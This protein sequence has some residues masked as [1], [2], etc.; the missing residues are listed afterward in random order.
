MKNLVSVWTFRKWKS[1]INKKGA[2][3]FLLLVNC[4]LIIVY[5]WTNRIGNLNEREI[6]SGRDKV[7][8]PNS[9]VWT[10]ISEDV[11]TYSAF[12]D[13]RRTGSGVT[14][15]V[16]IRIIGLW[17]LPPK[18][19]TL[20]ENPLFWYRIKEEAAMSPTHYHC[21]VFYVNDVGGLDSFRGETLTRKV[22][23]EGLKV[24]G[25]TFFNCYLKRNV[26]SSLL[27][28]RNPIYVAIYPTM[29]P[30]LD[31]Y[32]SKL[33][34]VMVVHREDSSIP[35]ARSGLTICVR[36]LFGPMEDAIGIRQFLAYY[37]LMGVAEFN[38][39]DFGLSPQVAKEL[40]KAA[41]TGT[42]ITIKLWNL[43]SGDWDEL[44][45]YGSLAALNDCLYSNMEK[46]WVIVI[47]LDEFMVPQGEIASTL[48]QLVEKLNI[49][50]YSQLLVR[51]TFFCKEFCTQPSLNKASPFPILAC[52]WRTKEIWPVSLRSKYFVNPRHVF[53]LGHHGVT[54]F[55][56][57]A[58]PGTHL[59]TMP[60][61]R[62]E[63]YVFPTSI[64]L[65]NHY[66]KCGP[67]S[68]RR[69]PIL[70][71]TKVRDTAVLKYQLNISLHN[72]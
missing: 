3:C 52:H 9:P 4:G 15:N 69:K 27:R 2:K 63:S 1:A 13:M 43:P 41:L 34:P 26:T 50:S 51:N 70:A 10:R 37:T 65:L 17:K 36:P 5:F 44:W 45:D 47:D 30:I 64:L 40:E 24:F 46:K 55:M 22:F 8:R 38:F 53:Q 29:D 58:M 33:I 62:S 18:V 68:T 16:P 19:P 67:I 32:P 60:S 28:N 66:R 25:S 6:A 39:Y 14:A 48:L 12:L 71:R 59:P 49:T 20:R 54:E 21:K 35:P 7:I 61:P 23:E 11:Y 72:F 42:K 31:R 57:K 56:E